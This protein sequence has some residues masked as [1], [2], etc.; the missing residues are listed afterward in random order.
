M[1]AEVSYAKT[2]EHP[3]RAVELFKVM[4]RLEFA[5]KEIGYCRPTGNQYALVDWDRFANECLGAAFF[6]AIKAAGKADTLIEA[7]P[8]RQTAD[9]SGH[10]S[11]ELTG[12]VSNT[13][14]LIGSL[15][16]VR[17]NLFHGEKSGDPD[18]DRNDALVRNAL[19]V[20]HDILMHDQD[21]R[22]MFEG[23][24]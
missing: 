1:S 8:N 24:Y 2:E 17:N 18:R 10:L 22:M 4:M 13:Q 19:T 15:R 6:D 23:K 12:P 21:L 7:P 16:R 11:W 9:G 14:E 5:I 20:I 3:A